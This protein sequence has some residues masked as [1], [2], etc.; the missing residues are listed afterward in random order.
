MSTAFASVQVRTVS[1][2]LSSARGS[3]DLC[4][5]SKHC[6][7]RKQVMGGLTNVE[8]NINPRLTL[9]SMAVKST[10]AGKINFYFEPTNIDLSFSW[11]KVWLAKELKKGSCPYKAVLRHEKIPA[12]RG[13][14]KKHDALTWQPFREEIQ[15]TLPVPRSG[16]F[17]NG[18]ERATGGALE[19]TVV[20]KR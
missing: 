18:W 13:V 17:A 14:F 3:T 2:T 19:H 16:F 12:D 1:A 7:P 4:K 6:D 5:K 10:N 15:I 11:V 8:L 9:S 20:S